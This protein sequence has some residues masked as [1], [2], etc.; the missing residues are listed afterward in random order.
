MYVCGIDVHK[1]HLWV[2][3]KDAKGTDVFSTTVRRDPKGLQTL[4]SIC[5]QYQVSMVIMESTSTYWKAIYLVLEKL[6]IECCVVNAY[7]LKVLGKHKSDERDAEL[8]ATWGLLK[9]LNTSF[10][11]SLEVDQLRQLVRARVDMLNRRTTVI[12]QMKTMLEGGYPGV[13]E[14]LKNLNLHYAQLF[15]KNWSDL[16]N[17]ALDFQAWVDS[18]EDGRVRKALLRRRDILAFWWE[19]P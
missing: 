2:H 16:R 1:I 17:R 3:I 8:L 4:K 5:Q 14:A 9:V 13:T 18:V 11:T 10:I 7:Q 6:K 15:L 12:S 19:H